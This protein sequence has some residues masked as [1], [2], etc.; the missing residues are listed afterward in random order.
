MKIPMLTREDI[1]REAE[2]LFL[3]ET[4]EGGVKVLAHDLFTKGITFT[5]DLYFDSGAVPEEDLPYLA[6]LTEVVSRTDTERF[7]YGD[8]SRELNL[9]T[10]GIEL[11]VQ[12]RRHLGTGAFVPTL[13]GQVE[14]ARA[15]AARTRRPAGRG[16][17]PDSLREQG[18]PERDR[19]ED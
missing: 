18:T 4:S 8:L 10:G 15:E 5:F 1:G 11:E 6:L 7:N 19:P 14:G 9:H 13:C 16:P 12:A 3:R 17:H 2:E